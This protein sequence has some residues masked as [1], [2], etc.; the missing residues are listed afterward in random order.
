MLAEL[1]DKCFPNRGRRITELPLKDSN[2]TL[3]NQNNTKLNDTKRTLNSNLKDTLH[4][5]YAVV[6]KIKS[7]NNQ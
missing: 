3:M 7:A 2:Y 1:E 5:F 4:Q 6:I